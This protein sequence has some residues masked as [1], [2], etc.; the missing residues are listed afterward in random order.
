MKRVG[1]LVIVEPSNIIREGLAKAITD[2]SLLFHPVLKFESLDQ[3][4]G[5]NFEDSPSVIIINPMLCDSELSIKRR[6]NDLGFKSKLI[7]MPTSCIPPSLLSGFDSLL[8]LYMPNSEIISI[9]R[10]LVAEENVKSQDLNSEM[11]DIS[12]REQDVLVYVANG[13]TN[14]EI[15]KKLN[16]SVHTVMSHRKNIIK[17]TGIKSISGLTVYAMLNGLMN[18]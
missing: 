18:K 10:I 8:N 15:A 11:Y 5:Y 16:I 13:K 12:E 17:K 7:A 4:N 9:I 14:K 2:T 1:S 3:F 6:L